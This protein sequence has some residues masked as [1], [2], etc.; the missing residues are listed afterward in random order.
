MTNDSPDL[1]PAE[2]KRRVAQGYDQVSLAYRADDY[3][4][5][6]S[7]YARILNL[8]VGEFEPADRIVELGCG[9]GIP[10]TRALAEHCR[11]TGVDISAVQLAR[12][13]TLVPNAD[14]I[15]AD[16][17]TLDF[18]PA[19]LAAVVAFW[20]II[21]IPLEDQPA[22]LA[23]ILEW[24]QPGGLFLC[25]VGYNHWIGAETDWLD[26]P[27]ATMYW[28]HVDRDTYRDWFTA[29]GYLIVREDFL[30]D[31]LGPDPVGATVFFARKPPLSTDHSPSPRARGEGA[32]G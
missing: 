24:L 8:V 22:L 26:V 18:R 11:V 2:Q 28:S 15:R 4:Y 19:S 9:N 25:S 14:F 12:A 20:S 21:H 23:R 6:N 7:G 27:G 3:D 13:R 30:P 29:A 16:M 10:V 31:T 5:T 32:G 17:A 1:T